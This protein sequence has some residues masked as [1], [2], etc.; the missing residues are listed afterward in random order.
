MQSLFTPSTT[1]EENGILQYKFSSEIYKNTSIYIKRLCLWKI[2]ICF[3][4]N[5]FLT[6]K[7][8]ILPIWTKA[9][10]KKSNLIDELKNY[11]SINNI[12]TDK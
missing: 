11:H 2:F 3:Q 12:F 1:F 6:S 4:N 7:V 9:N 10:K 5:Y 8:L